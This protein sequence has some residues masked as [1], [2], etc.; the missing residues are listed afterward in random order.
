MHLKKKKINKI[1]LC[2]PS[3]SSFKLNEIKQKLKELKINVEEI[4]SFDSTG[5]KKIVL[6]LKKI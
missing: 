2:L 3:V 4:K 6:I 5:F 1:F